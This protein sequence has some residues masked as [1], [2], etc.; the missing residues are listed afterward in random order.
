MNILTNKLIPY[1]HEEYVEK[2]KDGRIKVS[3][4][5]NLASRFMKFDGFNK[6]LKRLYVSLMTISLIVT[7]IVPIIVFIYFGWMFALPAFIFGVLMITF[8]RSRGA[9]YV[10][11]STLGNKHYYQQ[12][13]VSGGLIV[14]KIDKRIV[15]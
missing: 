5:K 15:N 12:V 6:G 3:V 13:A 11:A 4:N 2:Y 1:P 14:E 9:K 7:F 8:T 10:L